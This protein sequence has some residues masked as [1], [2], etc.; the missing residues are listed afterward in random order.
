MRPGAK[1]R[2]GASTL[3]PSVSANRRADMAGCRGRLRLPIRG[4]AFG[5]TCEN[6]DQAD[7]AWSYVAGRVVGV[8]DRSLALAPG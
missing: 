1:P 3:R 4:L 6:A 8:E 5:A 7:L 2:G